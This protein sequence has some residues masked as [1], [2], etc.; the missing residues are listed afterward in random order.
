MLVKRSRQHDGFG[1]GHTR[2][3]LLPY[4]ICYC[5]VLVACSGMSLLVPASA[6]LRAC[7]QEPLA[8]VTVLQKMHSQVTKHPF[9]ATQT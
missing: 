9:A 5:F 4:V 7:S 8:V 3:L 2:S 6:I 1:C